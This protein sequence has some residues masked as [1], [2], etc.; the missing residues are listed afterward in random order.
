MPHQYRR[1]H[2]DLLIGLVGTGNVTEQ[3]HETAVATLRINSC[4]RRDDRVLG[5]FVADAGGSIEHKHPSNV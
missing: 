4:R 3:F 5:R 2:R 1:G